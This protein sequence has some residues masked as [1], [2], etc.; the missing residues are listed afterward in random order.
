MARRSFS[1]GEFAHERGLAAAIHRARE[2]HHPQHHLR[3]MR[4]V[5]VDLNGAVFGVDCF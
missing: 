1:G 3:V 4:E 5:F 2:L